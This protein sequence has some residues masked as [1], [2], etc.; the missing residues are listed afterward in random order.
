VVAAA[1]TAANLRITAVKTG[2]NRGLAEESRAEL[3]LELINR[4][5]IVIHDFDSELRMAQFMA[6]V[7]PSDRTRNLR[8]SVEAEAALAM[9]EPGHA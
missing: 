5:P 3:C 6:A 2:S 7:W 9:S 4:R 8:A 1:N